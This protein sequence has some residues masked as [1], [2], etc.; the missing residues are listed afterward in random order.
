[1]EIS[2]STTHDLKA[3]AEEIGAEQAHRRE[4]GT[5]GTSNKYL[6]AMTEETLH[7]HRLYVLRELYRRDA[8]AQHHAF[9]NPAS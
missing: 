3:H 7:E 9:F 2:T 5:P 4:H 1:V 8:K 6:A